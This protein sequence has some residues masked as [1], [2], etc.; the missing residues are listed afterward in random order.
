MSVQAAGLFVRDAGMGT[1]MRIGVMGTGAVGAYF[2]AMLALAG[3]RVVFI[4]RPAIAHAMKT[5]GLR[6]ERAGREEVVTASAFEVAHDPQALQDVDGVL[7]CVKSSATEEAAGQ[8][9]AHLGANTWV[10][11]LQNGVDNAAR[12][13]KV[14]ER[15][16]I[17]AAVY[18]ACAMPE[19]GLVRHFGRGDLIIGPPAGVV[20]SHPEVQRHSIGSHPEV[21]RHHSRLLADLAACFQQAGIPV[22]VRTEVAEALWS[23]LLVNCA[24]NAIS[25]LGQVDYGTLA[26]Q[27]EIRATMRAIVEEVI[28]LGKAAGVYLN[29]DEAMH[30]CDAIAAGMPRQLSSTAQDLARG[31]VSEIEHLNGF[32]V[33]EGLRRGVPTPVNQTLYALVRLLESGLRTHA[34]APSA[35][36]GDFHDWLRELALAGQELP[37][38][39]ELGGGVSSDIWRVDLPSGPHVV[40]RALARLKV[41]APW[42]VSTERSR[43]EAAWMR[44]AAQVDPRCAPTCVA[45][46]DRRGMLL[47]HFLPPEQFRL[48]KRQLH[49]GAAIPQEAW[50]VGH[51]IARIHAT[52]A[53]PAQSAALSA[54]FDHTAL[55]HAIRLEPYLEA[56]AQRHPELRDA[57]FA[58]SQLTAATRLA[59]VHGD[60][61]PKNILI[62]PEGPVFL[63]AECA[64]WG[65]PA[66]DLAFCLNHLL[67]KRLWVPAHRNLYC[68][69]FD[70][71]I[72]GYRA[73]ISREGAWEPWEQLE[74][75]AAALLPALALA[76]VDG[77][78]PVEYL[79]CPA[80]KQRVRDLTREAILMPRRR[81][82]E[83]HRDWIVDTSCKACA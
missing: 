56:T 78:S 76:R 51:R 7:L 62:G 15:P 33:R 60:L 19:P 59:L 9:R 30:A 21:Q 80:C 40:K 3:H 37:P 82:D 83:V 43:H 13:H 38:A 16:V 41:H 24:Y 71:L 5:R 57:L 23:K 44:F 39:Q 22:T 34:V 10:M 72:A 73:G 14:L 31:K 6:L 4:A 36:P 48:W 27:A 25:A 77:K 28:A 52:S 42:E 47:M 68:A 70:A 29:R 26:A 2:G 20:G 49:D 8:L 1:Q 58:R 45:S 74:A 32:V 64:W 55:F 65:D 81:L 35:L 54:R 66:F 67:L 18:V 75:R 69:C 79:T 12:A 50:E 61:S 53:H 46:D 17:P 63:D 11:S